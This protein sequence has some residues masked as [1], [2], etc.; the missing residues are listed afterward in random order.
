MCI[1]RTWGNSNEERDKR[2][3]E[4]KVYRHREHMRWGSGPGNN[5]CVR[6]KK[7]EEE[8]EATK[9]EAHILG[10]WLFPFTHK[11]SSK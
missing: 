7:E 9:Q 1:Y 11:Y 8:E 5:T 3:K 10:H 2:D 4:R 6:Q